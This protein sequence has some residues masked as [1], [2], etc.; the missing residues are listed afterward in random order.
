LLK[1][2]EKHTGFR[3]LPY[4]ITKGEELIALLPLFSRRVYGIRMV[5]SPPKGTGIPHMG[6]VV[7]GSF[8][9]QRQDRKEKYLEIIG[10]ELS[11]EL[12]NLGSDYFSMNLPLGFRDVRI[13]Q[14]LGFHAVPDY[15]YSI[16][17]SPPLDEIFASFKSE[18]KTRIRNA[19]Q[20]GY[21]FR[22]DASVSELYHLMKERFDRLGRVLHI[23]GEEYLR[24]LSRDLPAYIQ[25]ASLL[26]GEKVVAA[27][28]FTRY[29]DMKL[30]LGGAKA[31][32]NVNDLLFWRLFQEAK[33]EG[34][35]S[36]ELVGANTRHLSL[37]KNQFNPAL[38]YSFTIFLKNWLARVAEAMYRKVRI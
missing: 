29:K 7:S 30:W 19:L 11:R 9:R 32:G 25:V 16:D 22:C 12:E 26:D 4:G 24:D 15:S 18:R 13:F 37:Y 23:P 36:V 8:D 28:M 38:V 2:V 21:T 33:G 17:L 20:R 3:F 35:R 27:C 1:I 5:A 34:F 6:L 31:S 14:W 10:T